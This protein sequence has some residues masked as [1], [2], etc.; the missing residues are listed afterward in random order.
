MTH[1]SDLCSLVI[2]DGSPS[3]ACQ[4]SLVLAEPS[5][6]VNLGSPVRP[7]FSAKLSHP[8]LILNQMSR[9]SRV[10]EKGSV[11]GGESKALFKKNIQYVFVI[12]VRSYLSLCHSTLWRSRWVTVLSRNTWRALST[13]GELLPQ[14]DPFKC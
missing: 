2:V 3:A 10:M 12:Q 9:Q 11:A 14:V 4:V 5:A 13:S 7:L 6:A 1:S 8:D